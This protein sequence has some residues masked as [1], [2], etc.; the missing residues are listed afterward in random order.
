MSLDCA[1]T[2]LEQYTIFYLIGC[3]T[4]II[5]GIYSTEIIWRY[6]LSRGMPSEAAFFNCFTQALDHLI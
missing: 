1:G 4:K 6:D 5:T 2:H 3:L